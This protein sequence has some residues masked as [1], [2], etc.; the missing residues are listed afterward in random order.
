[1][2]EFMGG[3]DNSTKRKLFVQKQLREALKG[4][5]GYED[6]IRIAAN[7]SIRAV[8]AFNKQEFAEDFLEL[9]EKKELEETLV[10]LRFN[11]LYA[12]VNEVKRWCAVTHEF[13]KS[14]ECEMI[15]K[16]IMAEEDAVK[17][18]PEVKD[19]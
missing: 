2:S 7:V 14:C 6:T 1:M 11:I 8:M 9:F 19:E 15:C 3:I 16:I 10:T 4:G 18:M 13:P 12:G 17:P 5:R